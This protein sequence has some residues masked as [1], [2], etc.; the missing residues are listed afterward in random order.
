M[1]AKVTWNNDAREVTISKN[2]KILSMFIDKKEYVINGKPF[3]MDTAPFIT[4]RRTCVPLAFVALALDC[5]V[6]W[7]PEDRKVLVLEQ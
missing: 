3:I 2:G 7:V 6:A 5:K 4:N 1:G